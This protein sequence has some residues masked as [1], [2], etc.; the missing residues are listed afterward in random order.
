M[1]AEQT[2][3]RL[4]RLTIALRDWFMV[5]L[6]RASWAKKGSGRRSVGGGGRRPMVSVGARGCRRSARLLCDGP[7]L[8][9]GVVFLEEAGEARMHRDVRIGR[10]AADLG[11]DEV[12]RERLEAR[13]LLGEVRD[14][15]HERGEHAIDHFLVHV[16]AH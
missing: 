2:K 9:P 7:V 10:D 3:M 12:A 11:A 13:L 5:A 15:L 1:I 6:T 16:G 14:V 8:V 4:R